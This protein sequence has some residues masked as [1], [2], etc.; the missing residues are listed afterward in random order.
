M[1]FRETPFDKRTAG[2]ATVGIACRG[3]LSNGRIT[4][5]KSLGLRKTACIIVSSAA[6]LGAW[7]P[8]AHA[9]T[10]IELEEIVVF[11][12][13]T[14]LS[15]NLLGR[16]HTVL[17]KEE[18]REIQVRTV[19]EALRHVPGMSVSRL[20]GHSAKTDIRLRGAESNHVLV[21]I[22]GIE[23]SD[24]NQDQFDWEGIPLAAIEQIEI[25]RGP[26]SALW[27][28]NA[29]AGVISITTTSYGEREASGLA[30][31]GS[32]QA[33]RLGAA[34]SANS[35]NGDIRVSVSHM[36]TEGSD[37][38]GSGGEKDGIRSS[39]P[40]L[41]FRRTFSESVAIG[42]SLRYLQ[43]QSETD[44]NNFTSFDPDRD[45]LLDGSQ[46]LN[47]REWYLGLHGEI[48]LPGSRLRH[49]P[50]FEITNMARENNVAVL[51]S[52]WR[53]TRTHASYQVDFGMDG[54][55]PDSAGHILSAVAEAEYVDD[56]SCVSGCDL[57]APVFR[58]HRRTLRGI[59]TEYRRTLPGEGSFQAAVRH[60]WNDR[61]QNAATWSTALSL[62]F[63]DS[64]FRFHAS[65]GTGVTNPT[66]GEQFEIYP[67]SF[68]RFCGNPDLVPERSLGWDLGVEWQP[69][70]FRAKLDATLFHETL[71]DRILPYVALG[72]ERAPCTSTASN[73]EGESR[74]RGVEFTLEIRP[75]GELGI[76]AA[77]TYTYSRNVQGEP[78]LRRPRHAGS[79]HARYGL[80]NLGAHVFAALT[81]VGAQPDR[82]F[83]VFPAEDVQLNPS[84]QVSA[85]GAWRVSDSAEIFFR[86]ENLL[87]ERPEEVLGYFG[88]GRE[89]FLGVRS[90]F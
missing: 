42:G 27:G 26:Q 28:A 10:I 71:R 46:I 14:P 4:V 77:Y 5:I 44:P 22:D 11:G 85:G 2:P 54:S 49:I 88:S 20:G 12:G 1:P 68:G 9:Q 82:D 63:A 73:E 84:T 32:N 51:D 55:P 47:R 15:S 45:V 19:S 43:R 83:R 38:S 18:I 50:R 21:L 70:A 16:A 3:C 30:E 69:D 23:V 86:V 31:I 76:Q 6:L 80:P 53:S 58:R 60:D 62:P 52:A 56:G 33:L 75:V 39:S 78:E 81:H 64:N 17:D 79:L 13:R 65:A 7:N 74:R 37:V 90:E 61:F 24:P 67:S 89:A 25:I 48:Q 41:S 72:P 35:R 59:A 34:A 40:A 8:A 66:F 36:Q 29:L 87:D 57:N